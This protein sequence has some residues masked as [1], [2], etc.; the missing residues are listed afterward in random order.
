MFIVFLRHSDN[1][2]GAKSWRAA[3][4]QWNARGFNDKVFLVAGELPDEQGL[5]FIAHG[6]SHEALQTRMAA[7]PFIV[8]GVAE[9][10]IVEVTPT[11]AAT[12]LA[13]L[14]TKNG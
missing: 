5:C 14:T 4:R 9:L 10:E 8:Q 7:A 2:A 12:A 3:Q 11:R 6:E 13:F 1:Q